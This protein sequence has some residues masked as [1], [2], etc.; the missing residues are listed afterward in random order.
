MSAIKAKKSE[1][2]KLNGD[3]KY[4]FVDTMGSFVKLRQKGFNSKKNL[5]VKSIIYRE[6]KS[7]FPVEKLISI[8][9]KNH[10][11]S[12]VK[13]L[14]PLKSE[15]TY[16][17]DGSRY[18][19]TISIDSSS[20]KLT[21]VSRSKEKQWNL[22]KE[23]PINLKKN[24]YCFFSQMIECVRESG[25]FQ[26][27][28]VTRSGSMKIEVIWD[29]HPFF[30]EQYLNNKSEIISG[31]KFSYISK[32]AQGVHKYAL[33]IDGQIINYFIYDDQYL[34]KMFWVSQGISQT[35]ME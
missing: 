16:W 21:V 34:A 30:N 33:S 32:E 27:A 14:M 26:R 5:V 4:E 9:K 3:L 35:L 15:V 7:D 1:T 29:G 22:K 19:S 8:S 13:L 11:I 17:F 12:E 31:G 28:R 18:K 24:A 25:F 6:N 2:R 23:K 10:Q 20:N